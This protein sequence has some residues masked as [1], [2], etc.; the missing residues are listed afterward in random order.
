[1]TTDRIRQPKNRLYLA[2]NFSSIDRRD[3]IYG[4]RGLLK[5]SGEARLLDP[6]YS[7]EVVEMYRDSVEAALVH[8]Q[9]ISVSLYHTGNE[10]SSWI[11]HWDQPILFR[12][13]F[14]FGKALPWKPA[15]ETKPIWSIDKAMNVLSPSRFVVDTIKYVEFYNENVFGKA[16]INSDGGRSELKQV[17]KRILTT[18][19]KSQLQTPFSA[20]V[21]TAAAISFSFGLDEKSD[22]ANERD[23]LYNFVAYLKLV[24]DEE[25]YKR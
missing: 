14:R 15:R 18:M 19:E 3:H 13:P 7:K 20:S 5:V 6:D 25:T 8:F 17:W 24:L 10:K 1:M 21:L 23:L 4:L 16:V 11:P 12:N 22:P 9:D 2:P